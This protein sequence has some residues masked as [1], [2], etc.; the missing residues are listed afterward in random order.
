MVARQ[1]APLQVC[2]AAGHSRHD[3]R[4]GLPLY[5]HPEG[6][7]PGRGHRHDLGDGRRAGR[8]LVPRHARTP[9]GHRRH[10]PAG[11]RGRLC[12]LDGRGRRP[13]RHQQYRTHV[14]RLETESRTR[15]LGPGASAA[16]PDHQHRRRHAGLLPR[17]PEHQSRRP[18]RQG[19]I[20]VHDAVERDRN[21]LSHVRRDARPDQDDRGPARRQ[22]RS[23]HQEP[24]DRDRDRPREG[25]VLR[26]LRRPDPPGALQRV[27]QPPGRH[28]LHADQRLPDHPG[29]A[30]GISGRY[31][32]ALENL[33]EDQPR[34][35]GKQ[36]RH[37]RRRDG[38]A[39]RRTACRSRSAPSPS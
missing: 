24:G 39:A 8:H 12:Q 31:V 14:R 38:S 27:R 35:H 2:D 5:R 33:P 19:R 15:A 25:R 16:A 37:G 29:D 23:L 34:Q 21:A 17:D 10:D 36:P 1:G 9:A 20:P 7:L 11:S 26:H 32:R 4:H 18:H 22:Q 28:D 6:L 13:E 30:A 3:G